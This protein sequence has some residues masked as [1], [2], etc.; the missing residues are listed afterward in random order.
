[1]K[2]LNVVKWL[3]PLGGLFLFWG[4]FAVNLPL[5]NYGWFAYDIGLGAWCCVLPFVLPLKN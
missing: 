3:F 1:M 4:G 2:I 5:H